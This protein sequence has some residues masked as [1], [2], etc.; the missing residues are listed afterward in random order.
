MLRE[1]QCQG[2]KGTAAARQ[3]AVSFK[4]WDR[5]TYR[6]QKICSYLRIRRP[7]RELL[8]S[9]SNLVVLQ[10]VERTE[11]YPLVSQQPHRRSAEATLGTVWRTFHEKDNWTRGYQ[12]LQPRLQVLLRRPETD[13]GSFGWDAKR[14]EIGSLQRR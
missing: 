11:L 1:H 13:Q 9:L 12:P 6:H 7:L 10:N 14:H 2:L 5:Q 8:Q 3:P 4:V